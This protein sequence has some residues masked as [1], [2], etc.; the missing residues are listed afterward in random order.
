MKAGA[1][2]SAPGCVLRRAT[3]RLLQRIC[4][5]RTRPAGAL[6]Q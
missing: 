2:G 6:S 1:A 5:L 3:L 4:A